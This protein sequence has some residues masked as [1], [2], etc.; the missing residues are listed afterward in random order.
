MIRVNNMKLTAK[1]AFNQIISTVCLI[2]IFVLSLIAIG[3]ISDNLIQRLNNEINRSS[4]YLLNADRDFYQAYV[5]QLIM[6]SDNGKG[7]SQEHRDSFLENVQQTR[8]RVNEAKMILESNRETYG[9]Y[10][11]K[12]SQLTIFDLFNEFEKDFE[13][14]QSFYDINTNKIRDKAGLAAKFEEARDNINQ[15]EEIMEEYSDEIVSE[16]KSYTTGA[17]YNIL[18]AAVLA[19]LISGLM[20][21]FISINIDQRTKKTVALIEKTA[22]LDLVHDNS[23]DRYLNDKDEFGIIIKAVTSVRDVFRETLNNMISETEKLKDT[24]EIT[25][26][27][28]ISLNESIEDISSTTEELSAGMEET[29]ATTQE[30]NATASEIETA[31]ENVAQKAQEG[32]LTAAEITNRATE[33]EQ[34]FHSSYDKSIRVFEDV[35]AR[36]EQALDN[37]KAV[38]YINVLADTIQQITKQTNLLALN[39]TIEAARAGE[40][41]K[42]FAVVAEEIRKL[43]ENSNRAVSEIQ[44]AVRTVIES[45]NNLADNSN[46][47]LNF[48]ANDVIKDYRTMLDVTRQY[49]KDAGDINDLVSDLSATSEEVL[50]SAQNMIKAIGE[51]SDATNEGAEGTGNIAEKAANIVEKAGLVSNCMELV[52]LSAVKLKEMGEKFIV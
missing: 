38:N 3:N 20:N 15:I 5:A 42:G 2:G 21:A 47:M 44:E 41:G 29:A 18:I 7:F 28:L 35:K 32:A 6:T 14:W 30:M 16:M 45:V 43:A 19:F 51:V 33:L 40:A 9:R 25:N 48:V 31:M 1:I 36:L 49:F 52:T 10:K 50:A 17:K 34:N 22:A 27:H 23:Y 26:A 12:E 13:E 4:N 37:S 11:H 46:T 24:A 39:A 8:E